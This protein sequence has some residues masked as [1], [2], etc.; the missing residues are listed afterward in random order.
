MR[1]RRAAW[2][3]LVLSFVI[4]VQAILAV[5]HPGRAAHSRLAHRNDG[6]Q[7]LRT[8]EEQRDLLDLFV[9]GPVNLTIGST[10][11]SISSSSTSSTS[12]ITSETPSKVSSSSTSSAPDLGAPTFALSSSTLTSSST[13]SSKTV[14]PSSSISSSSAANAVA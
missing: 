8:T 7:A 14:T 2:I 5:P 6:K 13:L 9:N 4:T 1:R 11:S 12:S 3:P 10:T